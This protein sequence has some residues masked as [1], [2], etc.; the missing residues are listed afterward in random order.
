MYGKGELPKAIFSLIEQ[1]PAKLPEFLAEIA[2]NH[3]G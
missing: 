1:S 2:G 3:R